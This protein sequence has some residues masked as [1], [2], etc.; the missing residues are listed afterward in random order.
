MLENKDQKKTEYEDFSRS[1][2]VKGLN[3]ERRAVFLLS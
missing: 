3:F 2:E 1:E